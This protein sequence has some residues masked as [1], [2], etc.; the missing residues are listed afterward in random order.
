MVMTSR[1]GHHSIPLG[2][3]LRVGV[4]K[5]LADGGLSDNVVTS[6]C[7]RRTKRA[8]VRERYLN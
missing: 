4:A 6:M 7:V 8:I 2:D 3:A 5:V 1:S